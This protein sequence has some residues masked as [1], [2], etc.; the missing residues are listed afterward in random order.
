MMGFSRGAKPWKT[1]NTCF[2]GVS[3]GFNFGLKYAFWPSS[4]AHWG[5][6]AVTNSSILHKP[7]G[8]SV[9]LNFLTTPRKNHCTNGSKLEPKEDEKELLRLQ[10]ELCSTRPEHVA[11][12]EDCVASE[13]VQTDTLF[14]EPTGAERS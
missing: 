12:V 10:T 1:M 8:S 4:Y 13:V 2:G 9:L 5:A 14:M 6:G 3:N 11:L 7:I